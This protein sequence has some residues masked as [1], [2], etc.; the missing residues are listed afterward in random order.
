M[1]FAPA[2]RFDF[3]SLVAHRGCVC[4]FCVVAKM[5][6]A[7]RAGRFVVRAHLYLIVVAIA[8]YVCC[9]HFQ[10]AVSARRGG[11]KLNPPN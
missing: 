2:R 3:F 11:L 6:D 1:G 9:T 8:L 7:R 5:E 10:R 4:I